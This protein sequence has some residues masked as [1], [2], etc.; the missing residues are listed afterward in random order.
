MPKQ[1]THEEFL[2]LVN[3]LVDNEYTVLTKYSNSKNKV[4]MRHNICG[5]EW[6]VSP[7]EFIGGKNRKGTRCPICV[8][9]NPYNKF[10]Y[11]QIKHYIEVESQSF[12]KL[13]TSENE[14]DDSYTKIKIKCKCGKDYITTFSEF[15][16]GE[17]QQ[18]ND[19][20]RVSPKKFTLEQV[21]QIIS[22]VEG[23]KLLT[24]HYI[25]S[26]HKLQIMC[27]KGHIFEKLLSD[28][29]KGSLCPVCM[30]EGG[31]RNYKFSYEEVYEFILNIGY[32]LISKNYIDN[33]S[34][35]TIMCDKGHIFKMSFQSLKNSGQRCPECWR[36]S[37]FNPMQP[38]K[39]H[40]RSKINQWKIDSA[41]K[42]N[43]KCILTGLNF[44]DIHH[45]YSFQSILEESLKYLN[46][47]ILNVGDYSEFQLNKIIEVNLDFHYKYGLGV[48]LN[49]DIHKKFH[50]TYGTSNNTLEQFE[51]FKTRLKSGEFN[52]FLEKNKIKLII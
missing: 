41:N 13:I 9:K 1:R 16:H 8:R 32:K 18:C 51:E 14:Y 24:K 43:F 38:L 30:F 3:D 34:K 21:E 29:N 50:N 40:L 39:I 10:S 35:L 22:S 44:D 11:D 52:D 49:R 42:C 48:C 20:G 36:M 25:D 17:K 26:S 47:P 31:F 6:N 2:S 45:L 4:L 19:C 28:F 27:P 46:Y 23:Y 37:Q 7:I 15:K 5:H 12:C 33:S